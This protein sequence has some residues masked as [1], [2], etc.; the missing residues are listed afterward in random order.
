[1]C[2]LLCSR[3]HPQSETEVKP[4]LQISLVQF[5]LPLLP[6][7]AKLESRPDVLLLWERERFALWCDRDGPWKLPGALAGSML[8][9]GTLGR[10]NGVD[11]G[12]RAPVDRERS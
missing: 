8:M 10:A 12:D 5:C 4:R 9:E 11:D 1:V 2:D 6:V 7:L 3:E